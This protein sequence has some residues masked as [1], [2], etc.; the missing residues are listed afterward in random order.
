MGRKSSETKPTLPSRAGGASTNG[1]VIP[2]SQG[3]KVPSC[4]TSERTSKGTMKGSG[5]PG[6]HKH[7]DA[8]SIVKTSGTP[9][10][11]EKKDK[12]Q[13]ALELLARR[14]GDAVT[15]SSAKCQGGTKKESSL[16]VQS[17]ADKYY[18]LI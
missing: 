14:S 17:V 10:P 5:L 18:L 7:V 1:T 3:L 15:S 6:A 8:S 4:D 13:W 11:E 2:A 12:R 9:D 16:L